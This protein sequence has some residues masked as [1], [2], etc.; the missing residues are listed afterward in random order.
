MFVKIKHEMHLIG[1]QAQKSY[2]NVT[3][4]HSCDYTQMF[5]KNNSTHVLCMYIIL[6]KFT[7]LVKKKCEIPEH[8]NSDLLQRPPLHLLN[9]QVSETLDVCQVS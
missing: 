3:M 4:S 6:K 5:M 2:N 9:P 7:V 8:Q 1:L